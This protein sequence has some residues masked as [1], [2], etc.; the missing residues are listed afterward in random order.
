MTP[1]LVRRGASQDRSDFLFGPGRMVFTI[2]FAIVTTLRITA[3]T[4]TIFNL[5]RLSRPS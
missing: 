3:T 1:L 2:A 4:S 5:P